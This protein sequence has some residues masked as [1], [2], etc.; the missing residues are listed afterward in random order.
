MHLT[1]WDSGMG[2]ARKKLGVIGNFFR[3]SGY[4][5]KTLCSLR[6][7]NWPNKLDRFVTLSWKLLPVLNALT[8]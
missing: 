5:F 1:C 3:K 6:N 7:M 8:Y 2:V 4:V